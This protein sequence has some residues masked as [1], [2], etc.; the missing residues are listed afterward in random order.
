MSETFKREQGI[1]E[2]GYDIV[3][4]NWSEGFEFYGD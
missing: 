3:G 1:A 2:F 4:N